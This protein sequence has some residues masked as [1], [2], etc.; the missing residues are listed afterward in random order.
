MARKRSRGACAFCGKDYTKAGMTNHLRSCK[1]RK[2]AEGSGRTT[3]LYHLIVAGTYATD[4]W[5]H[6][7]IPG[8]ATLQELDNF[9]RAIWL[10]CCGHLSRFE[11]NG[12][13]YEGSSYNYGWGETKDMSS[14]ISRVLDEGIQFTHEYDYG[15]T[16]HLTLNMADKR[17]GQPLESIK[18]MARNYDPHFECAACDKQAEWFCSECMWNDEYPFYCENCLGEHS[19]DEE[20][21]LPVTNSP[22]MG[23]CGY[24]GPMREFWNPVAE[25]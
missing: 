25:Q 24:G 19:C 11:I 10:E 20:M 5:L 7:E 4:S 2:T 3:N 9:L 12:T 1:A 8:S 22:R 6:L 18:I 15:T 13:A 21:A 23:E 16:T 14:S 17:K